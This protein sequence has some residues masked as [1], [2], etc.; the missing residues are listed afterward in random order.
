MRKA[1]IKTTE[2]WLTAT[3]LGA[4]VVHS[5]GFGSATGETTQMAGGVVLALLTACF[6]GSYLSGRL[7]LKVAELAANPDAAALK[8]RVRDEALVLFRQALESKSDQKPLE[9]EIGA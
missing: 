6:G 8:E 1:G 9:P 3:S 2:F 5:L 4:S 7:K